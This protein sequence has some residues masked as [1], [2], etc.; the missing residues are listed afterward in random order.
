MGERCWGGVQQTHTHTLTGC[1][2]VQVD[3]F[4]VRAF[5]GNSAATCL[6]SPQHL[7]LTDSE[8]QLIAADMNL[9]ETAFVELMQL[10]GS[11]NTDSEFNLRWCVPALHAQR[12][13]KPFRFVCSA[14]L[15]DLEAACCHINLIRCAM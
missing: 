3:A 14:E 11:F 2:F 15:C 6:L 1:G 13:R 7:P 5:R 10:S 12:E 4:T 9:A 8:R